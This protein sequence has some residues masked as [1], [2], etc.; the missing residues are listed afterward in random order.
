MAL[1]T[2]THGY[3]GEILHFDRLVEKT[4]ES[5]W[6]HSTPAGRRRLV[7]RSD[8]I[9]SAIPLGPSLH[10]MEVAAG[11]GALTEAVLQRA[12]DARITAT[13]ISPTSTRRLMERLGHHANIDVAVEDITKLTFADAS[14]NAVIGNSALHHVNIGDCFAELRRVLRPGGHLAVFEPNLLNPEIA[15]E[16]SIARRFATKALDYSED[17]QTHTR[18]TYHKMLENAGFTNIRVMPFDFLHPATPGLLVPLVYGIGR[19]LDHIPLVR[20][21]SGSLFLTARRA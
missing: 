19:V 10:I 11:A 18:W 16:S 6:G 14:F 1:S 5:W 9:A 12:P 15:I 13:D 21:I 4:G 2:P 8:M 17:E 3:A 20:E 7:R